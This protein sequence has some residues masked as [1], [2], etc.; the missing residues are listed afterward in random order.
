M[1]LLVQGSDLKR[2]DESGALTTLKRLSHTGPV[3]YAESN[4]VV[5]FSNGID[6]G[7][8]A[9]GSVHEWG[10]RPPVSQPAAAAG[11][12]QL[13]PGRYMYAMTYARADGLESGSRTP[14]V[15]E[16]AAPG[17]IDFSGMETSSDPDVVAKVL[18]VSPNGVELYRAAVVPA[19]SATYSHR[20]AG[21]EGTAALDEDLVEPA[22]PGTIVEIHAG[23]AYAVDGSVAWASDLYSL[24]RFRRARRFVQMPGPIT[25]FAAV[26]D[27]I[28]VGT[29]RETWF[30]RGTDPE[31]FRASKVLTYG[32]VPRTV[33]R[34]DSQELSP[35]P[36]EGQETG[37]TRPAAM[38]MSTNGVIL[39]D[40]SGQVKNLTEEGY[41]FPAALRGAGLFRVARG[42]SSYVVA[43]QAPG[44]AVNAH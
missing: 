24:E 20:A 3:S 22:P 4:G 39:G 17:G 32:A 1:C 34:L 18:Y 16:L 19:S 13:P 28:Y 25:L 15:L 42:Y 40:S 43:L 11:A 30:L 9:G 8:V 2:M 21:T 31:A 33:V 44:A 36:Q 41:G 38:W 6:T 23:V 14:G 37:P 35:A 29:D 5:Y 27:G 7:R 12:G 26:D 10:I